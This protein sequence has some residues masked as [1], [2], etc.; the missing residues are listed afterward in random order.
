MAT[1]FRGSSSIDLT[2]IKQKKVREF[3][4]HHGLE[5]L[6]GFSKMKSVCFVPEDEPSYRVHFKKFLVRKD[7]ETVWKIYTQIHPKDAWNG[8]MVSFG[9]QYSQKTNCVNYLDDPYSGMEKGQILIL[10]L[11]IFGGILKIAVA[12]EVREVDEQ[13]KLIKLSYMDGGASEGSQWINLQPTA[14]GFT[15]VHHKTLYKSNSKFRDTVLYPRLH[16]KAISEFHVNVK[17]L[18]EAIKSPAL[19]V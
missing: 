14:E 6:I 9:L 8:D 4:V 13:Q 16:T 19:T 1:N 15:E 11:S 2:R 3:I 17:R 5:T 7:I 10:N 12:H 18:A